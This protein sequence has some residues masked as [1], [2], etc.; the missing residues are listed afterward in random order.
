MDQDERRT[1]LE[2]LY[3]AHAAAV[4]AYLWRRTDAATADDLLSDVFVVAWRRLEQV[5]QDPVPWLLACARNVL[6]N[7]QRGE[8]RRAALIDRL[9]TTAGRSGVRI[10]DR[11]STL[12]EAFATLGERD[13]EALLLI[14]W[15]GLSA[16]QAAAGRD[17]DDEPVPSM[18]DVWRKLDDAAAGRSD[19]RRSLRASGWW[20]RR[21]V[22]RW[23][24]VGVAAVAA[25][26][27]VLVVVTTGGGPTS[28][29]AG[30]TPDPTHPA[31]GQLQA[32][33]SAC[34]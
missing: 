14:A 16:E 31:A 25:A 4:R 1:R 18:D 21:R 3:E 22:M 26:V 28:A 23:A 12:A 10:E 9:T 32:G 13:R 24:T 20:R 15:D 11:G 5:P 29:F 33:E 34:L 19:A 27:A 6:A 2:A 30:W 8:R 17:V 7:S